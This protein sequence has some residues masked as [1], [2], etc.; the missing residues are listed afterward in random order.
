[1]NRQWR[2][3][4]ARRAAIPA[5]MAALGF[6]FIA[7]S[8]KAQQNPPAGNPAQNAPNKESSEQS[9]EQPIYKLPPSVVTNVTTPVTV[10]DSS[11]QLVYDLEK[12]EF[13]IFD[14]GRQQDI[15][16]FD[17]EINHLSLA[18]VVETNDASDPFLDS[19]R[20]LG[21]IFSDLVMGRQGEVALLT[22]SDRVNKVLDFTSDGDKLDTALRGLH[23]RG[24]GYH[25]DDALIYA[26]SILND[27]PLSDR[28]VVIEFSDGFNIGSKMS[29]SEI[30]KGAMNS[31]IEIYTLSFSPAKGLWKREP[32]DPA[33]D[34]VNESVARSMPPNTPATPTYEDNTW[35]TADINLVGILLGVGEEIKKPIFKNSMIYFSRYSGGQ[36]YSKWDKSTVQQTLTTIATEIHSQYEISY[37][38]TK[39]IALGYH[40]IKV[41][42]RRPGARVRA[43]AG[44]FYLGS[45]VA[46][47]VVVK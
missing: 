20:P 35:D 12:D 42:V 7:S 13:E 27:R 34:L 22:Y 18:I 14:N 9:Q 28:K 23:G 36:A 43:R 37:S 2:R 17:T 29:R 32:K 19:V 6:F 16:G 41:D 30:V 45:D 8:E 3:D 40:Q 5:F 25:S 15:V 39:P 4:F 44:W 47:G 33:P 46:R 38:P 11:G 24:G 31:N 10:F 26:L 21:S 1:M